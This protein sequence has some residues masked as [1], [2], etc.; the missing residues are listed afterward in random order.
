PIIDL[1][2]VVKGWRTSLNVYNDWV[3]ARDALDFVRKVGLELIASGLYDGSLEPS[4]ARPK[5]DLLLAEALWRK[6]RSDDPGI[7]QID[8]TQRSECVDNFRALDHKRIEIS[9]S[10]VFGRYLTQ[11]PAGNAGEM[12]VIR[13]EIGKKRRHLPIRRLLERAATAVQ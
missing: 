10:E 8:G 6:A 2:R 3:G 11:R 13:A 7:D 1:T 12:G 9:R 5:T 4:I